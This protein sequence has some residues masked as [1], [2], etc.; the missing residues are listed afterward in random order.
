M[1][2]RTPDIRPDEG[3]LVWSK[4]PEF[5]LTYNGYSVVIPYVEYYLNSVIKRVRKEHCADNPTLAQELDVFIAQEANHAQYHARFNRRMFGQGIEGLEP[6]TERMVTDLK[7]QRAHRSLAFN[8]AYCVGFECIATFACRYIHERCDEFFQDAD[9]HGANLLLWHVAEEFEHRAV[10]H[11]A[12]RQ[13]SGNYFVRVGTLLYAFWHIWRAFKASGDLILD[14]HNQGLTAAD[15]RASQRRYQ[16]VFWRQM[17]YVVP[18]MLRIVIPYYDPARLR[19][20]KRI[21]AAL[22]TYQSSDFRGDRLGV[23]W[24]HAG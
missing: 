9:P 6:L 7:K 1:R 5:A 3:T 22:D 10:C 13:V 16:H 12:F 4:V 14:H 19:V 24:A 18:R 2:A 8:V 15:R 20:P 11:N 17:R 21:Q 23:D